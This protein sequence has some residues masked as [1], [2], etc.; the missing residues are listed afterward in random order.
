MFGLLSVAT[1]S[2]GLLASAPSVVLGSLLGL[3]GQV[4][5]PDTGVDVGAF[6]TATVT[7]LGT[8]VAV[9]VGSYFGFLLIRKA[10]R[11]AR[12]AF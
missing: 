2:V 11:W 5:L 9:I 12:S 1:A 7:A 8:I 4:T 10:L 6:V 3:L